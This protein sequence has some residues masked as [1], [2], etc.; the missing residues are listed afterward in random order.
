MLEDFE[1]SDHYSADAD[2]YTQKIRESISQQE[3]LSQQIVSVECKANYC[4]IDLTGDDDEHLP[5]MIDQLSQQEWWQSYAYYGQNAQT[6]NSA[7]ILLNVNSNIDFMDQD[8]NEELLLA[9]EQ[10]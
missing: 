7:I 8:L 3:T 5:K 6:N 10:G 9:E 4:L 2:A 1:Q